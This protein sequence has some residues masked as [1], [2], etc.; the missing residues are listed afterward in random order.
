MSAI[1]E[2]TTIKISTLGETSSSRGRGQRR[3]KGCGRGGRERSGDV[4]RSA[5]L[6][7]DNYDNKGKRHF[8]KFKV[9]CRRCGRLGHYKNECY[10]RFQKEKRDQSNFVEKREEETLLMSF[11]AMK[12][13]DQ[14]VWAVDSGC[15]N[16]MTGCKE[17]FS[18]LNENFRTTV[19]LGKNATLQVMRKRTVDIKT[20]NGFVE[21]ISN[22]FYISNLKANLHSIGQLQEKGFVITFQNNECET[23]DSRR[24]S[25]AKMQMTTNSL[26]PLTLN[27]VARSLMVKK[28]DTNS[29]CHFRYGHLHFK[30]L[31]TLSSKKM[32]TGLLDITP[33]TEICERCVVAKHKRNF[34]PFEKSR[35]ARAILELIH[36]DICGPISPKSNGNKKYFMTLID[37]F[38]RKT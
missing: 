6:V 8:D 9:E 11:H 28:E 32:A 18:T 19:C 36:S 22:M 25:I 14:G 31:K 5:D 7:R 30:G 35:R 2:M 12:V 1:E 3:G 13:A 20:R 24:G 16:H 37:D 26:Y 4:G 23:Y 34:F 27:I 29:L 10:T 21:S 17:F 38:S 15:S 33:P